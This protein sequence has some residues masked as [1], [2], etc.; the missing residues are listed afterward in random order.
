VSDA[1]DEVLTAVPNKVAF[2]SLELSRVVPLQLCVKVGAPVTATQRLSVLVT[3][4]TV[5]MV[6]QVSA[7]GIEYVLSNGRVIP[8]RA[9]WEAYDGAGIVMG[10][11]RQIPIILAWAVTIYCAQGSEMYCVCIG[12][13]FD[14]TWACDGLVHAALSCMCSFHSLCVRVQ[15]MKHMCTSPVCLEFWKSMVE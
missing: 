12:F 10:R 9:I 2:V 7:Q 11:R 8:G 14:R 5:G 1:E 4:V 15:T 3:T 6:S 13:A